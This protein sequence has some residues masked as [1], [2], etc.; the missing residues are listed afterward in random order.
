MPSHIFTRLGLWDESIQSNLKSISA[1]QCYAE[2]A[3]I[4]GH[5]DEE[6]HG[7]DYLVYAYLQKGEN[8]LAEKQVQYLSGIK[9]VYPVNFKVAY[10]F[11]SIPCR[12]VLE[13]KKW[14]DAAALDK[15]A[16][17]FSWNQFPWQEAIIHFTRLLGDAHIENMN[18]AKIELAKLNQLRD[19]LQKQKD[20]YKSMEVAIQIKAGEAWI[21]FASGDRTVAL[22][23]MKLAADMEDSTSKHPVTP[24]EVLPERE[25]LGD[26]FLQMNQNQNAL[27]AYEAVLT[28]CPN[29][30]NSLHGAGEAAEKAGE[31]QKAIYYYKELSTTTDS[32]NSDRKELVDVRKFLKIH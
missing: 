22:N 29:R 25:L 30:F 4:P 27:Q 18:G 15:P 24:G 17:N 2:A 23:L 3:D 12:Y 5:W 9:R 20:S 1:A 8:K 31:K 26:M 28:K 13:N 11:A 32:A 6:L 10:A 14:K 7:L 16:V 21:Q 19:T